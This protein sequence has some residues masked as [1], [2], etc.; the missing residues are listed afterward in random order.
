MTNQSDV[1]TEAFIALADPTRRTL[2]ELLATAPSSVGALAQQ[3]PVSRSA[4]SQHLQVLHKAGLIEQARS[5]QRR[6]YAL[7]KERQGVLEK[8]SEY[9][10]AFMETTTIIADECGP[11]L[12]DDDRSEME[13]LN[14]QAV[15][16]EVDTQVVALAS[17]F[18]VAG[19]RME[20][21]LA[22]T[23]ARHRL[24][25]GEAMILG[26]LKRLGSERACTPTQLG[27]H[28]LISLPGI[29]KRLS[30]LEQ[31]GLIE[32]TMADQDRRSVQV[33]LTDA[34]AKVFEAISHEQFT[35]SYAGFT[36]L[37]DTQ[38]DGLDDV[39]DRLLATLPPL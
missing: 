20:Q 28:S 31:M 36:A 4:V 11:P 32:R 35:H 18:Y 10:R 8:L 29:A 16:A 2:F 13:Q 24:N 17:R 25:V 33:N 34:G 38:R 1:L 21:L 22:R 3:M 23:A 14:W 7:R 9:A 39:L 26:T 6:I 5:G 12:R 15:N 37:S 19:H 27:R 30:R